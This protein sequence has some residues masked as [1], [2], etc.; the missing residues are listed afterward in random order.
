MGKH[1]MFEFDTPLVPASIGDLFSKTEHFVVIGIGGSTLPLKVF[2]DFFE[3]NDRIHIVDTV[4]RARWEEVKG[5]PNSLFCV[6]SKSGETLEIKA[7]MAELI[8]SGLLSRTLTVTDPSKGSLRKFTEENGLPSLEI[9]STIGG[10]FTNFT[11]FHR[12]LLER[13][14]IDFSQ[15]IRRAKSVSGIFKEDPSLLEKLFSQLFES[16]KENLI[17]WAYGR[18]LEGLASWMQQALAESL[19]KKTASG[20]R[21]GIFPIVLRGP[22]DQHS[23]LQLLTDGPQRNSLWFMI[24]EV[25]AKSVDRKLPSMLSDL[26]RVSADRVLA[27]LA[28]ST[29]R[30][31]EERL[32]NPETTQPLS[33][34]RLNGLEDLA[35]AVVTIQAFVEYAGERLQID[36]FDQPGVE[37]GKQI[38]REI[39]KGL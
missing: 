32:Q 4:D 36:A 7:L 28:E 17:L 39:L 20:R 6:V 8:E 34:F 12:A 38:A 24:P 22:Q 30:T 18:K 14:G 29:R 21:Y 3:L 13:F 10:R 35:E 11:V 33:E 16:G 1:P 27:I 31:F 37:R 26:S 15:L 19:G 2:L 23:V 5:L 25:S 9:P